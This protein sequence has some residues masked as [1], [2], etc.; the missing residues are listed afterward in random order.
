MDLF[1]L[2]AFL[3]V[4]REGSFSAAAKVLFRTQPAVSQ[5]I[6]RLEDEIGQPLFDRSSRRGVLTDAGRVLIDHAERL[7]TARGRALA[8]LDDVRHAR[9]GRL[10]ILVNE[11]TGLFVL[12]VLHEYRRLYPAVQVT[13]QRA[14]ASRIPAQVREFGADVGVITY[15]PEDDGLRTIVAY[16]DALVFVVPAGHPLAGRRHVTIADLGAESFVAHHV[17][18]PYRQKV[19]DAFPPPPCHTADAGGDADARCHQTL[20]RDGQRRG[21]AAGHLRG[22][23]TGPRRSRGR[24]RAGTGVRAALPLRGAAHRHALAGREGLSEGGRADPHGPLGPDALPRVVLP[25]GGEGPRL[26][27]RVHGS[28]Q[29]QTDVDGYF[30]NVAGERRPFTSPSA[31]IWGP[32]VMIINEMAGSGGDLMPYMFKR[33]GIGPLVGTRTWGGLVHTADTPPFIDGGSM[34][35]PRGGF[36][37][38]DGQWAVE[39]EGVG[40]DIEVENW[41][42]DVIAGRDPQL[43]R[44]V[45]EALRLLEAS[46]VDRLTEEPPPPTWGA[47]PRPDGR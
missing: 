32:K 14:P 45:Q 15:R 8:E 18:S 4:A 30:N 11:L 35:A 22:R 34:I 29:G 33:R 16:R 3:A 1:Q 40:A 20:R 37:T 42:K 10:S 47:R 26:P 39:N 28:P 21:V 27:P 17:A 6:K 5:I 31:G 36:F 43:E 38:R 24:A 41:P 44:A 9:A 13:V 2:E 46:P 25:G 19:I 7:V 23:R 12:P